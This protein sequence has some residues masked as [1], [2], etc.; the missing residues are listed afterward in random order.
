MLINSG[1]ALI[2]R[3]MFGISQ[4]RFFIV[5]SCV[6]V[7]AALTV[8]GACRAYAQDPSSQPTAA[9]LLE[10]GTDAI[11]DNAT[12]SARRILQQLID[13]YPNSNEAARARQAMAS[14]GQTANTPEVRAALR[15]A[16]VERVRQYRKA[17]LTDVGDRVFFAENSAAIGGRARSVIA[18]QSRWLKSRPSLSVTVIGRADDNDPAAAR[19]LSGLRAA[20]VRDSLVAGGLDVRRIEVKALGDQDKLAVCGTP[21]CQAQNRNVEIFINELGDNAG[22]KSGQQNVPLAQGVNDTAGADAAGPPGADPS[23]Q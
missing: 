8:A 6:V 9:E 19:G 21:L 12:E 20:A 7:G 4:S 2:W 1:S 22:W 5:V 15:A 11:A 13:T 17:F 10:D 3:L 18:N 16:D 14:I 23:S